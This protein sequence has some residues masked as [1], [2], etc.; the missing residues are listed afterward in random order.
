M[1]AQWLWLLLDA[2]GEARAWQGGQGLPPAGGYHLRLDRLLQVPLYSIIVLDCRAKAPDPS[3]WP[4]LAAQLA[5]GGL[6]LICGRRSRGMAAR[7]K[8]KE[9]LLRPAG[10]HIIEPGQDSNWYMRP[11]TASMLSLALSLNPPYSTRAWLARFQQR[12]IPPAHHVYCLP[13][14]REEPES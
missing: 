3:I 4:L 2:D 9:P 12:F 10:W 13:V 8:L 7:L 6:L 1:S 11:A 5:P 14:W